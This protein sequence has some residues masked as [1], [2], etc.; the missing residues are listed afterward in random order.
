MELNDLE[1]QG[2]KEENYFS[3]HKFG[4]GI[5]AGILCVLF[6][7]FAF[8]Q[9][10]NMTG[11]VIV[12]GGNNVVT[13]V[14]NSPLLDEATIEKVNEIYAKMNYLYYEDFSADQIRE[15]MYA[16]MLAG[17][18]DPYSAYYTDEE[19]AE[20][21]ISLTGKY[22]GIGAG[23]QQDAKTMEVTITKIYAGTPSEEA[24]LK[25]GDIVL[26]VG[27]IDATSMEL[28][29]LVQ[30]I[31]GEEGTKVHMV[32]Y[33][34]ATEETLEFDVERRNVVL[35]SVEG[36][37]LDD[38]IGYIQVTDFQD[39]TD[40]QFIKMVNAYMKDGMKGMIVDIRSNP[41]GY[42]DTVNNMLDYILPEGLIVY[43][44]GAYGNRREFKSDASCIDIPIVV[45]VNENSASASE[46]FAGA[47]K[48]HD[49]GTI[50]GKTTFGKG[51]VQKYY[52]LQTGGVIK[53]T[54][55]KYYTP[56]G[57]Y[58]HGVGIVPHVEVDYEYTGAEDKPYDKQYDS[59]FLQ[60]LDIMQ[61]ELTQQ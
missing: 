29:N 57:N 25:E 4:F 10:L 11:Q 32:V 8:V 21:Q 40:E 54:V 16:G 61:K 52:G 53:L 1:V 31:R 18:A 37:M 48:D 59:Q 30:N 41:G 3:K 46:I 26:Y 5:L 20:N 55:E 23:L 38:G 19:Y 51:L 22:Y 2:L 12:I 44:E 58:I 6:A 50:V 17:L 56:S 35:P 13:P 47:I 28:S 34:P 39:E 33:R 9:V 14:D 43:T 15:K 45:L 60:A 7:C 36:E 42:L 24:G 27:D 49:Y